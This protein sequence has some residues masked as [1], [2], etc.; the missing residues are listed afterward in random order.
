VG[1][2]AS[3]NQRG[4]R[5]DS[6]RHVALGLLRAGSHRPSM[7]S[8][9]MKQ[10]LDFRSAQRLRFIMRRRGRVTS[11]PAQRPRLFPLSPSLRTPSSPWAG[12]PT[13]SV[14]LA[15]PAAFGQ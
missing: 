12:S 8:G 9:R 10:P 13:L 1:G 5:V 3:A 11:K 6:R 4:D 15:P 2:A 7:L 14:I